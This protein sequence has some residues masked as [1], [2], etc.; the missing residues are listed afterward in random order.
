[1]KTIP[2]TQASKNFGEFIDNVQREPVIVTRKN[3]AVAVTYSIEQAKELFELKV[4]A[5]IRKG[6]EDLDAGRV[7]ELTR[8]SISELK[9]EFQNRHK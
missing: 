8:E 1:M 4:D 9:A 5:G 2:A 7:S 6:L 3:R